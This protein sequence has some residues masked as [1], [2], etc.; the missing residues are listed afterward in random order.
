MFNDISCRQA[1]DSSTS[2]GLLQDGPDAIAL[3]RAPV[4]AFPHRTKA[5]PNGLID[6][7]VYSTGPED[8]H[9]L[10]DKLMPG[11]L[12]SLYTFL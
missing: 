1:D 8:S 12:M 11:K 4:G 5:T 10:V 6:A 3:Y 2:G 9:S 7:I